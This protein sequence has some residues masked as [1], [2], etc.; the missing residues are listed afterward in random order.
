MNYVYFKFIQ[1]C[2]N[3]IDYIL[4]NINLIAINLI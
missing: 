4:E 2:L 1:N 3:I